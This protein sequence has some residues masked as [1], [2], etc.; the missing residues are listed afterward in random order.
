MKYIIT[1]DQYEKLL[2][3]SRKRHANDKSRDVKN[4]SFNYDGKLITYNVMIREDG[5][6]YVYYNFDGK[7]LLYITNE[8]KFIILS[9]DEQKKLIQNKIENHIKKK[10]MN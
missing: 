2:M 8:M 1:E 10:L 5:S 3:A 9:K 4:G 7:H 6:L